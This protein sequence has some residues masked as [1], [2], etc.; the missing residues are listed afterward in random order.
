MSPK[1]MDKNGLLLEIFETRYF[2]TTR[3]RLPYLCCIQYVHYMKFMLLQKIAESRVE[4]TPKNNL[5]KSGVRI[6]A[7]DDDI[8][9]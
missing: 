4:F 7:M 1:N 8:A 3:C 5:E 9:N 6:Y 2:G